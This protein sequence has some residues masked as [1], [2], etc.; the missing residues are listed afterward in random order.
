MSNDKPLKCGD[1]AKFHSKHCPMESSDTQETKAYFIDVDSE[2]CEEFLAKDPEDLIQFFSDKLVDNFTLKHFCKS[3]SSL[4]LFIWK[5]GRYEECEEFLRSFIESL[6]SEM[7]IQSKVKTHIVNEAVEKTKRRTYTELK[8]EPLRIAFKNYALDWKAFLEG[9]LEKAL[10]PIENTKEEPIFHLIPHDLNVDF[11]KE[12]ISK[13]DVDRGVFPF[14]EESIPNVVKVFKEWVGDKW[15]LLF[16]IIGYCLYPDYP[17]NKSF[18]FFGFGRNGKTTFLMLVSKI[19]GDGNVVNLSLQDICL[20]RFAMCEL[21]HKL[22]NVFSDL[23]SKPIG[24]TGFFKVLTGQDLLSAPR[25]FRDS[26]QFRNY[27]KLLFSANELPEVAD[28]SEAFW[29]RWIVLE[30]P[31]RFEDN[32]SFFEETFTEDV[33]ERIIVLGLLAFVNVYKNR[34]FSIEASEHD[35]KEQWLRKANTIYAYVKEG[36]ETG[37]LALDKESYTPSDQLFQD[38]VGWCEEN[39]FEAQ[40]K[41]MFTRELERLFGVVKKQKREEEKRFLVYQGVKLKE[42]Y[43]CEKCGGKAT[44][45]VYREGKEHWFCGKC[46]TEWEGNY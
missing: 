19:L 42:H 5:E 1:C 16:E 26:I 2:A 9:D 34:K 11:F 46:V 44:T 12:A 21:Y 27:A 23:P 6:A 45:R 28:M 18:M 25:K 38:Y 22:A 32:P 35:F 10:I 17:F 8:E 3:N 29:R 15:G 33:L 43:E 41:N 24:Y 13:F 40:S 36:E 20:Y 30:F 4:G 39:D 37:R 31:N 7:D 14:A